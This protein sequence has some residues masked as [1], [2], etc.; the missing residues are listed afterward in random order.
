[1]MTHCRHLLLAALLTLPGV[2]LATSPETQPEAKPAAKPSTA[3]ESLAGPKVAVA[4]APKSIIARDGMGRLI[5]P[6]VNPAEAA[7]RLID[8]TE[9]EQ[10]SVQRVL[11]ARSRLWDELVEKNVGALVNIFNDYQS[12]QARQALLALSQLIDRSPELRRAEPLTDAIAAVLPPEKAKAL[13]AMVEQYADAVMADERSQ[14]QAA[15]EPSSDALI[16]KRIE[17]KMAGIELKNAYERTLVQG[18][19]QLDTLVA[20]L[21]LTSEQ[22]ATLRQL[23]M[24]AATSGKPGV[25]DAE[26][27]AIIATMWRDLSSEQRTKLLNMGR[28]RRGTR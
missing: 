28:D 10:A 5:R 3:P 6:E 4:E 8:L 16:A 23:I 20:D 9:A 11:A 7:V 22:E 13:R 24:D 17:V 2:A 21:E 25:T 14:A 12:G 26:R 18:S 19:R 1:M 15:K 27:K